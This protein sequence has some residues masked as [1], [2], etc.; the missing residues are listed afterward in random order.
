MTD[1]YD[2]TYKREIKL[3]D[4]E[5]RKIRIRNAQLF[6]K[7]F[8]NTARFQAEQIGRT[9]RNLDKLYSLQSCD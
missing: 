4:E 9:R 7:M 1:I 6:S 3:T 2:Y 8:W 5:I